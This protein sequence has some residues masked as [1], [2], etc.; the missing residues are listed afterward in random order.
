MKNNNMGPG[1][2]KKTFRILNPGS[3][4]NRIPDPDP[5]HCFQKDIFPFTQQK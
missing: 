2:E 4:K 1:S 3:K 5:Q